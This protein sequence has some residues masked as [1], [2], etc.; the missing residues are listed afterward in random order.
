MYWHVYYPETSSDIHLFSLPSQH[1]IQQLLYGRSV[2]FKVIV[3]ET[4]ID[5]IY[6]LIGLEL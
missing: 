5:I 6:I 2:G 1:L 3:N 4:Y